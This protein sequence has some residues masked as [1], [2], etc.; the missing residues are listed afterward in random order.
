MPSQRGEAIPV[1]AVSS[2]WSPPRRVNCGSFPVI[3]EA[4]GGAVF[5]RGPWLDQAENVGEDEGRV[6]G[7]VFG[8]D[9]AALGVSDRFGA[10]AVSRAGVSRRV[11]VGR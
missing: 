7:D 10:S 2:V 5:G 9:C 8:C 6:G 3:L 1:R 11:G 4:G